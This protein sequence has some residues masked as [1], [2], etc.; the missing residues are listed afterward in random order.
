MLPPKGTTKAERL[1]TIDEMVLNIAHSIGE[2]RACP[3]TGYIYGWADSDLAIKH[4][5]GQVKPIVVAPAKATVFPARSNA[6]Y[7]NGREKKAVLVQRK[8]A[9][10]AH[11][12]N[13]HELLLQMMDMYAKTMAEPA[14]EAAA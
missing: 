6:M 7:Y 5:P 11:I 8:T 12:R 10:E 2:A 4:E 9:L 3:T 13:S 14:D 1:K